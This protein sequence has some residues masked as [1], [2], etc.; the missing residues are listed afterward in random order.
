MEITSGPERGTAGPSGTTRFD[1]R[2]VW[3][4]VAAIIG[5]VNLAQ[6]TSMPWVTVHEG[7]GVVDRLIGVTPSTEVRTYGLTDLPGFAPWLYVGWGLLLALLVAAW[8]RPA[9]RQ[10]VQMA[11]VLISVVLAVVTLLP[12]GVAVSAS[13]FQ[14]DNH[15]STDFLAGVW[16]A[17]LGML[18]LAGAI[19][20]LPA[21]PMPATPTAAALPEVVPTDPSQPETAPA[22]EPAAADPAA[23]VDSAPFVWQSARVGTRPAA[24]WWRRP[25]P[26]AGGLAGLV[27]VAVLATVIWYATRPAAEP[28]PADLASLVVASPADSTPASP[29]GAEDRVDLSRILPLSDSRAM[30]LAEQ[31]RDEVEHTAGAAWT[32]PDATSVTVTLLQ[33]GTASSADQ[34]QRTY[35]DLQQATPGNLVEIDDVPGAMAF[36]GDDRAGIWA[37]AVREEIVVL[38]SAVGGSSGTLTAI[39][40][41]VREQ[42][43]RL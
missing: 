12:G 29:A 16:S 41:L 22:D 27:A 11:A 9:W 7:Q 40:P 19:A 5:L 4:A 21:V 15:P 10:G 18:L 28:Q 38:V 33:F 13:G 30:L 3:A 36:V 20:T 26:L 8:V 23:P 35:V 1:R 42:Y 31:A 34:F 25:G 2:H 14:P 43:D 37:V 39:E 24:P 6:A 17:L 32:R